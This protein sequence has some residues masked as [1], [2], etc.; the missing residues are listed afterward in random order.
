MAPLQI[1]PLHPSL[2]AEVAGV[3]LARPARRARPGTS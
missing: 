1:K 2:G 3:D